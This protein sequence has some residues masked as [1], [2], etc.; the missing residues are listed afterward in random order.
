M[1]LGGNTER[2]N[3]KLSLE[4]VTARAVMQVQDV[5]CALRV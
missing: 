3:L 5:L 4:C 1:R 2:L